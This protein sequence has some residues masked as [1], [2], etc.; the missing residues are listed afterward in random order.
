MAKFTSETAV[1]APH[2]FRT[3]NGRKFGKKYGRK[4]GKARW[5]KMTQEEKDIY[6]A[7]NKHYRRKTEAMKARMSKTSLTLPK[8]QLT[9]Q[10]LE[11]YDEFFADIL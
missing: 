2:G 3:N 1:T 4:G 6:W 10:D 11:D 7:K 9:A 5:A 8:G